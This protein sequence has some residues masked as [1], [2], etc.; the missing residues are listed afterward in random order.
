MDDSTSL[1]S[2][3]AALTSND[4][5]T[6]AHAR[7]ELEKSNAEVL[8]LIDSAL[9]VLSLD[10]D[11]PKI[12]EEVTKSFLHGDGRNRSD[13][14]LYLSSCSRRMSWHFEVVTS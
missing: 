2:P 10:D 13:F 11:E 1:Q 6:W 12:P 4:R 9:F 14:I 7:E 8:K 5:D 3:I